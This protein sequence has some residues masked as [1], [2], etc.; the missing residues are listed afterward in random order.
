MYEFEKDL[1]PGETILYKGKPVPG[2][3]EK[4]VGGLLVFVILCI[5]F[6]VLLVWSVVNNVGDGA[7]IMNVIPFFLVLIFMCGI[8]IYQIIY[9]VFLK[10]NKIKDEYY[11]ITNLRVMKYDQK[12]NELV[13]GHIENYD[14][15]FI[16]NKKGKYGDLCMQKDMS[17]QELTMETIMQ[18]DPED[19]T[20]IIF[21][22]IENPERVKKI[23]KEASKKL[24]KN[25]EEVVE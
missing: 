18:Q 17:K 23:F 10:N 13:S 4:N 7:N 22:S 8:G 16:D 20:C 19:M 15:V 5:L 12:K 24:G 9:N 11:C 2:K 6:L 21:S 14:L 1:M 3:S 25:V